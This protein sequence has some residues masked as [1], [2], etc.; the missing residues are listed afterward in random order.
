MKTPVRRFFAA[1]L[2]G[3]LL[4]SMCASSALAS[5]G[6]GNGIE[7]FGF[8]ASDRWDIQQS[9]MKDG[10]AYDFFGLQAKDMRPGEE[11]DIEVQLVNNAS[12][13]LLF[14]LKARPLLGREAAEFAGAHF[15]DRESAVGLL[16][17]ITVQV[18]Y[19]DSGAGLT[20]TLYDGV[21]R[22]LDEGLYGGGVDLGTLD[23]GNYGSVRVHLK[24]EEGAS[25]YLG[26]QCSVAWQFYVSGL[27]DP[28]AP[29]ITP[30]PTAA[31]SL[32]AQPTPIYAPPGG[33]GVYYPS[34]PMN[35]PTPTS[36]PTPIPTQAPTTTP[37]RPEYIPLDQGAAESLPGDAPDPSPEPPGSGVLGESGLGKPDGGVKVVASDKVPDL[38]KT[39]GLATYS[40]PIAIGLALLI[41]AF[42]STFAKK[43]SKV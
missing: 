7:F 8:D 22:G 18:L 11:A 38:A 5:A 23:S 16:S 37:D 19:D 3:L 4:A 1:T 9:T 40:T 10:D 26:S 13:K 2:S 41:I 36:L 27:E 32:A 42:L 20:R 33:G 28:I 25:A 15:T 6:P 14:G 43:K 34:D 12:E 24:V 21:F 31:P 30:M 39:G 17:E 29:S 35:T